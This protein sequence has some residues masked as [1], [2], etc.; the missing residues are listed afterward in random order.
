MAK[1]LQRKDEGVKVHLQQSKKSRPLRRKGRAGI[2]KGPSRWRRLSCARRQLSPSCTGTTP[3]AAVGIYSSYFR[4]APSLRVHGASC[5]LR[6]TDMFV[7]RADLRNWT[8]MCP[9]R[10]IADHCNPRLE[11]PLRQFI[12]DPG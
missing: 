10:T 9:C 3:L 12:L 11:A 4:R 5:S 8:H 6:S 7:V 1:A 2:G